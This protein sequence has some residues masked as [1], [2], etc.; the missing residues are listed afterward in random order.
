MTKYYEGNLFLNFYL[1]GAAG[2]VGIL[3]ALPI[4]NCLQIRWSFVLS[5][6]LTIV[7]V[8]FLC[9]FQQRVIPANFVKDLGAP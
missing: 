7:F 1:D 5:L 6:S 9:L 3:I 8:L 4:Y 2:I